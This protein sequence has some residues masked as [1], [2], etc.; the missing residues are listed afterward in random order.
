MKPKRKKTFAQKHK[1]KIILGTGAAIAA[2]AGAY[3]ASKSHNSLKPEPHN[4]Y[5]HKKTGYEKQDL[6]Y[7]T[8]KR[9]QLEPMNPK[10][11]K[12]Y[13]PMR[14]NYPGKLSMFDRVQ[15]ALND[16]DDD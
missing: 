4:P 15:M 9:T 6:N 12:P 2:G 3:L 13:V 8:K 14:T 16:S 5:I 7:L 10:T 1:G 11:G